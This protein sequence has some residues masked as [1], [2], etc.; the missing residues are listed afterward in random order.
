[1]AFLLQPFSFQQVPHSGYHWSGDRRR[2]FEGWYFRVTLSECQQSFAFMYS[3]EDPSGSSI[4]SGGAAQILGPDDCYL[5][6]TFPDVKHFW[7]WK[8][9]LGLGHWRRR[10]HPSNADCSASV[11]SPSSFPIN[12]LPVQSIDPVTS[13]GYQVTDRWHQGYLQTPTGDSARWAFQVQPI[14][15]WGTPFTLPQATAGWLSFLPIFEPGWQIL[16]AHGFATG[17][18]EWNG[19]RYIFHHSPFYAE[20]NWGGSFPQKWFWIQCNAF[21]TMPD[22]TLTAVGGRRQVLGQIESVGMIGIHC[23]GK[24]Y[25]F[26][27][28]NASVRWEV[29]PWGFWKMAAESD[30]HRVEVIGTTSRVPALVRVPTQNGLV[31]ACR[32]TTHGDLQVRLWEKLS[33][34][35]ILEACSSLAGLETGGSWDGVWRSV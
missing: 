30:R 31:F 12:Y 11:W 15:R 5:C 32:D 21:D 17:W 16:V 7:A 23:H 29:T 13:E 19:T 10:S 9:S 25:E 20:K 4:Y 24:F 22:L 28:W 33:D 8:N 2:F 35:L 18:I 14:Y 26:V 6:R 3:I 1:M 34:R 27:P